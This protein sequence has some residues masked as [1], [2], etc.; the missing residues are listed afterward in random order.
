[1]NILHLTVDYPP[2]A[3]WGMGWHVYQITSSMRIQ[4]HHV[5]IATANK[6]KNLHPFIITTSKSIDDKFLSKRPNHL[7]DDYYEFEKWQLFLAERI[8]KSNVK[9]DIIHCHNWTSWITT[10]KIK[11]LFPHI[12]VVS[13]FHFLQKQYDLMLENPIFK[14]NNEIIRDENEIIE[15]ADKVIILS[16]SQKNLIYSKYN[17]NKDNIIEIPHSV[18]LNVV[19]Y[20]RLL[21]IRD[22]KSN[23]EITFVGRIEK[24]KGIREALD[25]H[26]SVRKNR[27][28]IF[29]VVGKGDLLKDLKKKFKSYNDIVFY[30]YVDRNKL[31]SILER[32]EI[33]CLPSYSENLPL[34]VIEAL[35]FGVVPI[36]SKGDSVPTI[37]KENI[38]GLK[39]QLVEKNDKII[40]NT[41][42]LKEKLELLI[43][44]K[45]LRRRLSKNGYYFSHRKYSLRPITD[46]ILN[47]YY[48][49]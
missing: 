36:F 46:Q 45:T 23:I 38:H 16:D 13:T 15:Q 24:D 44:K 22:K 4:N 29:N 32:S 12:K 47:L 17:V 35:F 20:K 2:N 10:K 30:G 28:I 21:D 25:A 41:K 31:K 27:K 40:I 11:E 8:I 3:L 6:S 9:F 42:D 48:E 43:N 33:F 39:T 18:N 26:I 5:Y 19:H 14:F 34:T 37:Y 1:M 49:L 7:I